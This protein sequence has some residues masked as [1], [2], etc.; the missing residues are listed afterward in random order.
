MNLLLIRNRFQTDGIFGELLDASSDHHW[1]TL[2]H[3]FDCQPIIP[4]GLYPCVRGMHTLERHPQ[5]FE[6]F[7]V[8]G[9]PGHSGILFHM[10][11]FNEDTEGCILL[12]LGSVNSMILHSRE[13]FQRFMEAQSGVQQFTLTIQK[14]HDDADE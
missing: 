2:E 13:A 11:N 1:L 4:E 12:G 6:T 8:K 10:G 9:V 5:P 14:G 3:S 7:E